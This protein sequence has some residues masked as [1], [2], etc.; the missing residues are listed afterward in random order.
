MHQAGALINGKRVHTETG[1]PVVDPSTGHV[2]AE[3]AH[4]AEA[5][6]DEAVAA[7]RSAGASWRRV[8]TAERARILRTIGQLVERDLDQ[9]AEL[10]ARQTGKPLKQARRDT[11]ITVRYFDFYASAIETFYGTTIPLNDDTLIYSRWEPHGVTG[12]HHAVELP[13]ADP[14]ALHRAVAGD[15]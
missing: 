11:E 4:C 9:L 6:V 2:F 10:E 5:E 3:T 15:G 7:A 14:R 1:V 13:A 12:A 8:A